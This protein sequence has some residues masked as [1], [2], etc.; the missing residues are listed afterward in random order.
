MVRLRYTIYLR[1]IGD[2]L[3]IAEKSFV[4]KGKIGH[5]L[6]FFEI[7]SVSDLYDLC[8]SKYINAL[9]DIWT[10]KMKCNYNVNLLT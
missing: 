7:F 3:N 1:L 10:P 5:N 6:G 2:R 8:T 4:F 9:F